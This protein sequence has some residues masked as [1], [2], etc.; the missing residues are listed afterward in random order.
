M[1]ERRLSSVPRPVVAVLVV[2][3][4]SQ[5][6]WHG[7]RP[8]PEAEPR[9]LPRPPSTAALRVASLGEPIVLAKLLMLW[10]QS[11]DNQPGV[12]IPFRALDYERVEAWLERILAL[13][14][15]AQYPLLAA[16]RVY[17]AVPVEA[18]QRRML[19]FVYRQFTADPNRRWRWLAHA[20][21]VARHRLDDPALALK[22]ARAITERATAPEVPFWARDL[23]VLILEDMGELEAARVLVGGLLESGMIRDPSELRFLKRKLAELE[24]RGDENSTRRRSSDSRSSRDGAGGGRIWEGGS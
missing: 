23:T 18:K 7:V 19:D 17:A 22:Y 4:A 21:L 15:R 14:P 5:L 20:A 11:F 8:G 9:A 10:L 1:R 12:S 6:L 3:L 24:A 13:D 16:S 2:G